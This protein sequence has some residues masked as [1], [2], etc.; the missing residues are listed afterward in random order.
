L[1]IE[2]TGIE[3]RAR[4]E[5]F[6]N[7]EPLQRGGVMPSDARKV[8]LSYIDGY[9]T[10][11]YCLGTLH[12]NKKPPVRKFLESLSKF[13]GMDFAILT[14]G[15]R[16]AKFA[17]MHSIASPGDTIVIDANKH[18]TS[19]VAAERAGLRTYEVP[20]TGYPEFKV[21]P[22]AYAEAFEAIRRET[23]RPP[24]LA[25]LT[26]VDWLYGN[27]SDARAVGKICKEYGIPFLLNTAYSSGRMPID[28]KELMADFITCSGHKSW[29]SGAGTI[30]IL[31]LS[32]EWIGRVLRPSR[33]YS[34]KPIEI[35]GCSARGSSTLALMASFPHVKERVGH[36]EEEVSKARWFSEKMESL[37]GIVQ[38]GEKPHNHDLLR[39][40]APALD[41]IAKVHPRR[42][43]F[44]YEELLKRGIVGIK[45]GRTRSF[46][47]ST[48]GLSRD[49]LSYVIDAFREILKTYG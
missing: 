18:Y 34:L 3:L 26:H 31:A 36:W 45:P 37:G 19:L 10:C 25:L 22:Q 24:A 47:L 33:G 42:G 6:I 30:G 5:L 32:E 39:F 46:E 44:L 20:T 7:L 38:L 12:M 43:F 27:L 21:L 28:G 13:L 48:Y 15:C 8:A 9:S 29:A 14:N 17:I 1:N 41:R 40:E 23:G 35:L 11:D 49:Q 16:E 2:G 4:E